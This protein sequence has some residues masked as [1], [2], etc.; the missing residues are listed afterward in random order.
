MT[1]PQRDSKGRFVA[2]VH[3]WNIEEPN[4]PTSKA[5]CAKCDA[6]REFANS[7]VYKP[8]PFGFTTKH[9]ASSI[10][11]WPQHKKAAKS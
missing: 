10:R 3:H 6:Q 7:P 1:R 11:L 2:C 8:M 4:G 5:V 9:R